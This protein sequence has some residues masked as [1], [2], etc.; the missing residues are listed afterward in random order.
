M[1][2]FYQY[3]RSEE[4]KIIYYYNS[5]DLENKKGTY[6]LDYL[7]QIAKDYK[8]DYLALDNSLLNSKNRAEVEETLGIQGVNATT[9][10]VKDQQIVSVQEGFLESN[11]LV[12]FLIKAGILNKDSKYKPVDNIKFINY[13]E[14]LE[15]LSNKKKNI[16]VVGEAGCEYCIISKPILNNISKGYKLDINYIDVIE[17][18][19]DNYKDFFTNLKDLGYDDKEYLENNNFSMPTIFIVD[20]GKITSYL[21]GANTLEKYIEYFKENGFIE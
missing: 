13:D 8:I 5:T 21:A 4:T 14:Y 18:N 10:V 1:E 2:K 3:Y 19:E 15:I 12:E 9:V 7:I 6:E 16:I 11:R 17:F 20:N